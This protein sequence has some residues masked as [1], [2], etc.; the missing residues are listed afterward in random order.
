ML[1]KNTVALV[2]GASQGIGK[3]IA[4]AL[5][6]QGASVGLLSRN[7]ALLAETAVLCKQ[8]GAR[9][10][11]AVA[12][13]RSEQEV[14][15]AI[16]Q[17]QNDLG[18]VDILVNSAGVSQSDHLTVEAISPLEWNSNLDVNLKG[19]YLTC[20]YLLGAMKE[21]GEGTVVNIGS[22]AAHASSAGNTAYTA[23]KFAVRALT[24]GIVRECEGTGVKVYLVS[25]GPVDTPIW[26]KKDAPPSQ[27]VRQKMLRPE[28]I[29]EL[30]LWLLARP[31]HVRIDEIIVQ[32]R[33]VKA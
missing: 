27:E 16:K 4:C 21:R 8:L 28:D 32:P 30:V 13:I 15:S 23:S 14:V 7:A 29:A 5:A 33:S 2:T 25:P 17:F 11:L 9:V 18:P 6:T 22:T 1:Q 19:T 20:H 24:E 10:S 31:A 3:A 26:D 12:D